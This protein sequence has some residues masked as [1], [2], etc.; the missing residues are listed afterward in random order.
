MS[1]GVMSYTIRNQANKGNEMSE[2]NKIR[3]VTF[4]TQETHRAIESLVLS[5][6][7]ETNISKMVNSLLGSHKHVVDEIEK[8][9]KS[10]K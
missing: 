10:N 1:L 2:E 8:Q 4:V 6:I 9:A 3:V 5:C 7:V